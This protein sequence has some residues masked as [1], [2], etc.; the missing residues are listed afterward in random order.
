M[1]ADTQLDGRLA[2]Y[3]C[4]SSVIPF[5]VPRRTA[6]IDLEAKWMLHVA[7]F[8]YGQDAGI[9]IHSVPVQETSKH[10]AKFGWPPLSD[11]A[12]VTKPRRETRWN[13]LGCQKL[14]NGSQP[15]VSRSSP[16]CEDM[17]R[18][19]WFLTGF[20]PIVNAYLSCEDIARQICAIVPRWRTFG[21]FLRP[22]FPASGMQHISDLHSKFPLGPHHV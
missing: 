5:L 17:W 1:W 19:Y 9:C 3:R 8:R 4:E 15:L 7:K 20:F 16:Q 22:A 2:E 6:A 14:A 13:L 11:V 12:A 18:R 21:D 10:R